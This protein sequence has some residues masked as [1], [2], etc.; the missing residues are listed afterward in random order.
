MKIQI[1]P[2]SVNDAWQGRRFRTPE[3]KTYQQ[4]LHY[5]LPPLEVPKWKL[6]IHYE[7]GFSNSLSDID[8]PIKQ[9]Q[10]CLTKKYNFKDSDIYELSVKKVIVPKGEEYIDFE[11]FT[12]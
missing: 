2:L 9:F 12:I 10:D 11:I 6:R 4:I 1:K 5:K 8:N 3:Y 7:F